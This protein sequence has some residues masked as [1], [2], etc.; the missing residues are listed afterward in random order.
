MPSQCGLLW[1]PYCVRGIDPVSDSAS[2][3]VTTV[4]VTVTATSHWRPDD[5]NCAHFGVE[6]LHFKAGDS[7]SGSKQEDKNQI[8]KGI[9]I[10]QTVKHKARAK[11]K[12][13]KDGP[14]PL[15]SKEMQLSTDRPFG[16]CQKVKLWDSGSKEI[17]LEC[18]RN[19]AQGIVLWNI[20]SK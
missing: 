7:M 16:W 12:N 2:V 19:N 1:V 20:P 3:A 5:E 14:L 9:P 13:R 11:K 17:W 4:T 18:F 8:E 15:C 10:C 6:V